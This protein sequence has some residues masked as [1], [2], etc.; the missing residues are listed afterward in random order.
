MMSTKKAN[1]QKLGT[2]KTENDKIFS[3]LAQFSNLRITPPRDATTDKV[4]LR[5]SQS[6]FVSRRSDTSQ[7]DKKQVHSTKVVSATNEIDVQSSSNLHKFHS[8]E[9][10]VVRRHKSESSALEQKVSFERQISLFSR[11][12]Y[13]SV[14]SYPP[15]SV[16]QNRKMQERENLRPNPTKRVSIK[17][18]FSDS[19]SMFSHVRESSP[20][21]QLS[22]SKA[23]PTEPTLMKQLTPKSSSSR[24]QLGS[25]SSPAEERTS[26]KQLISNLKSL[27]IEEP[28]EQNL[29]SKP[30]F[31]KVK[32]TG[33]A[34]PKLDCHRSRNQTMTRISDKQS[35]LKALTPGGKF[36]RPKT[37]PPILQCDNSKARLICKKIISF[38]SLLLLCP[39]FVC[40]LAVAIPNPWK[41]KDKYPHSLISTTNLTLAVKQR[42]FGQH[43]VQIRLERDILNMLNSSDM[44]T[45]L[46]F[47]STGTGKSLTKNLIVHYLQSNHFNVIQKFAFDE[48]QKLTEVSEICGFGNIDKQSD[49]SPSIRKDTRRDLTL[50]VEDVPGYSIPKLLEMAHSLKNQLQGS[51]IS[52]FILIVVSTVASLD[53]F[54]AMK[55]QIWTGTSRNEIKADP[56]LAELNKT[57]PWLGGKHLNN[58][59]LL[60]PFLP[61]DKHHVRLCIEQRLKELK[62]PKSKRERLKVKVLNEMDFFPESS[63]MFSVSGC[64]KVS[65]RIDITNS[66][67]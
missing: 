6:I 13:R 54:S 28:P 9:S 10:Y 59:M 7:I 55:N 11:T 12:R 34:I 39:L 51:C 52:R 66:K 65:S 1:S 31:T 57:F 37:A 24:Q 48:T 42:L 67:S 15:E 33:N 40:L 49:V 35:G 16:N 22:D 29:D 44:L 64:K 53:M 18:L 60:L 4:H 46:L 17:Q 47:G 2:I 50:V 14:P 30:S 23:V 20:R 32:E 8:S 41:E 58:N 63:Q 27:F 19:V 26:T 43:L 3:S 56:L 61:L 25:S 45:L 38:I 36:L 5:R 62:I 21:N